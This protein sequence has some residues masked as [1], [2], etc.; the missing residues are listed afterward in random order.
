MVYNIRFIHL[1]L[2]VVFGSLTR[3][4]EPHHIN[5]SSYRVSAPMMRLKYL[6]TL[7][8]CGPMRILLAALALALATASHAQLQ[9]MLPKNGKLGLAYGQQHQFPMVQINREV[10]RLAPGGVIVDRNNRF[11]VHGALPPEAPVL[12][13][14]DNRG[15]ISRII[16]LSPEELTRLQQA[17]IR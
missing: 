1:R 2:A 15:Q 10:L 7:C 5:S 14:V 8:Y 6:I 9:R 11:I 16:L 3:H 12:Y 17:G 13:V 4:H